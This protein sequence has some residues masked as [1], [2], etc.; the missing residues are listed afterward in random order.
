MPGV[1]HV[2]FGV[3]QVAQVGAGAGLGEERVVAA[4]DHQ[5]RRPV[6]PQ[7][8]LPDGVEL[9]IAVVVEGEFDLDVLATGQVEVVLVEGPAVGG[10]Q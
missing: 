5:G 7:P 1:E 6:G 10:D 2:E 4:P 8:V 9:D 3:G